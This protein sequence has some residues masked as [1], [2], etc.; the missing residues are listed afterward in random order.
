MI[1]ELP[2]APTPDDTA[3]IFGASAT[4]PVRHDDDFAAPALFR[5]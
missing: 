4:W 2:A 1:A 3:R 5:P